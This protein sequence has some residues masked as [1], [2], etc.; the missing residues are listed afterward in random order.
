MIA[1]PYLEAKRPR[2]CGDDEAPCVVCGQPVKLAGH[3]YFIWEHQGGGTAVTLE[4]GKQLNASGHEGGD[5]GGQPI[6]RTCL[7]N[8]PELKPYLIEG[9]R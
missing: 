3:P 2:P 9:L 5:L 6:G 1:I 7:K 8:H 4:E